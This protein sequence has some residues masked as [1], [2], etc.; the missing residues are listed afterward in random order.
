MTNKKI[1]SDI[2]RTAEMIDTSLIAQ[3]VLTWLIN[4][5]E[6]YVD[7]NTRV[8]KI[9]LALDSSEGLLE[10][11]KLQSLYKVVPDSELEDTKENEKLLEECRKCRTM[12]DGI[13]AKCYDNIKNS[14][15]LLQQLFD[16]MIFYYEK[17]I[18][19]PDSR[20]QAL[21]IDK[22]LKTLI[23]SKENASDNEKKV[24]QSKIVELVAE[25]EKLVKF[26]KLE[27]FV[28][29]IEFLYDAFDV[30]VELKKGK[31]TDDENEV[32]EVIK[33][34]NIS[35]GFTCGFELTYKNKQRPTS[36]F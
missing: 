31:L 18:P 9:D 23:Q 24:I 2:G 12:L 36:M 22:K 4:N 27:G 35:E 30:G 16:R 10:T 20:K 11:Q 25:G 14:K 13:T 28:D 29:F 7:N 6:S 26:D 21:E 15:E 5:V 19:N 34:Y 8:F 3:E 33:K 17:V 1:L 32:Q